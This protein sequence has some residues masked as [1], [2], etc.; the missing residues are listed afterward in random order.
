MKYYDLNN[1]L[2][3][4]AQYNVIFGERSNGKT[5][6][7]LKYG[8]EQYAE[9]KKQTAIIRRWREDFTGKRGAT[10]F[11]ALVS[12][13]VV[14][15]LTN[16][17]WTDV[18]Y[19]GSRWWLCRYEEEKRIMDET[20]FAYGF[21]ISS[22]EHD[23]STSYPDITTVVFDEFITRQAY[24]P[25]EFVQFMN[26][27][28]TIIRQRNDVKIFMLGNTVNKYCPYF[29]EMG[30]THVKNMKQGTIDVYKYGKKSN[31]KVAVEYVK[32]NTTGKSSDTY[33]AFDNSK[34]NMITS[35]EW[36]INVYPHCPMKYAPCDV[37]FNYYVVF[38]GDVL[39]C[40][41]VYKDDK[42]F[43]FV[44]K[45]TTEIKEP[46]KDIV[47]TTD[48]DPRPNWYR[49]IT[50]PVDNLTT[51]IAQYYK[52]DKIFYADNETGEIMRNYLLWCNKTVI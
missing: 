48:F 43:T 17:E 8:L 44:H 12:A 7:A 50:K 35:G 37:V 52:K 4:N 38:A 49:K 16:G 10:M 21:A 46:D 15:T 45:K 24:L 30:L 6:A 33:F 25:D 40:E 3:K 5:F 22:G 2:A 42:T 31:L 29:S 36:E 11:D 28:S 39:H 47:F 34:L 51:K 27:L 26:V 41:V 9:N 19:Y 32:P 18:Y 1:I 14:K 13:G 23:K 20:P